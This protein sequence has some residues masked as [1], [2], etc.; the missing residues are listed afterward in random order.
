MPEPTANNSMFGFFP[1]QQLPQEQIE[2][3]FVFLPWQAA[4]KMVQENAAKGAGTAPAAAS[5]QPQ[6]NYPVLPDFSVPNYSTTG[7]QPQAG[8]GP[9]GAPQQPRQPY[10]PPVW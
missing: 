2:E 1:L 10:Y 8:Y 9:Y 6:E 3:G 5:V 7:F 4:L